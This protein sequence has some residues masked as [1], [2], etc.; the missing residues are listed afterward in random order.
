MDLR[1][2]SFNYKEFLRKYIEKWVIKFNLYKTINIDEKVVKTI[3][4]KK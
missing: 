2:Y 1:K 4:R 3:N